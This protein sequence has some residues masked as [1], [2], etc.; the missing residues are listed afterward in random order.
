M[1]DFINFEADVGNSSD[2]DIEAVVSDNV[3][4]NEVI[5]DSDIFGSVEIYYSF[6]NVSR[7]YDDSMQDALIDLDYLL[8]AN[9]YCPDDYNPGVDV[10][11]EFKKSTKKINNFKI[12]FKF[13][14]D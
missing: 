4:D 2:N 14:T 6:R 10:I 9:N 8:E 1:A 12:N 11:N 3:S 13:A 5:V 7:G